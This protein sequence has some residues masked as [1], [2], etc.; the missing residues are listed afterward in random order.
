MRKKLC[1]LMC[2]VLVHC[3]GSAVEGATPIDVNNFSF[4][5]DNDGN[6]ILCHIGMDEVLAWEQSGEAW[7]GV[8]PYCLGDANYDPCAIPENICLSEECYTDNHDGCHCWPATHGVVWSYIQATDRTYLYQELDPND[9]NAIIAPG[10]KYT[11]TYD[12]MSEIYQGVLDSLSIHSGF[13]Y[14]LGD[15]NHVDITSTSYVL[16]VWIGDFEEW[17][18]E[19]VPNLTLEWVCPPGHPD[20][21]EVL[22]IKFWTPS[23]GGSVRAYVQVDNIRLEWSWATEAF[24]PYPAD[25]AED[26]PRD[27][28][29]HWSPG[30]W[31]NRHIVYFSDDLS[32]VSNLLEDA[33]QGIHDVNN[34]SV[35]E[36]DGNELDLAKTYYWRIVEVNE[37]YE[38]QPGLSDPPWVGDVWSFTVTGYATNPSPADGATDVSLYSVLKW[39]PGTDSEEHDIYF[40][41]DFD[42]VNDANDS[43]L[44]VFK[45]T[46]VYGAN[47]YDPGILDLGQKYYWRIDEVRNSGA[48]VVKGRIW[49]F[50][51][52][53]YFVI[54]DMESYGSG[55]S[56]ITN[57]WADYYENDST[58]EI[59]LETDVNYV[60]SGQSMWYIFENSEDPYYAETSR[61]FNP[62][63][64]WTAAGF[65]VLTL[66]FRADMTN[67]ASA[68]QPMYVFISDGV[69]TGIVKYDDSNDL[70]RGWIGWQEWNI[71]L[72]GFVEDEP[73]LDLSSIASMGIV[74]G[75]GNEAGDGYVYIDDIRL[76][77]TRCVVE[78]ATGSFTND[79]DVD[80]YDLFVLARDWLVS[81]IG[82]ITASAPS[83]TGLH[84]RWMMNDNASD[85]VVLD[86][87]TNGNNGVLYDAFDV[88]DAPVEG[89]TINHSVTPGAVD[90]Y[91]LEFDGFDDFVELPAMNVS[92]N[93]ITITAWVKRDI[94]GHIYDGIVMS[95]NNYDPCG[96]IPGPNYTAGL[97]FGSDTSDW[98]ANY[99]LSFMWTGFS[100]EWHTE[101]FVAPEEW[102]FTALTVAPDVATIYLSDGIFL[103]AA[104]N[105]DSYEP[106]P[107]H[108]AFHI[109][110]QM[111]F[112]PPS[113]SDRFFPGAIDEVCIYTRTL[114]PKEIASLAGVSSADIP[115][116]PWRANTDGDNDVDLQDYAMMADNWL[117]EVLWP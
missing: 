64:D 19:W 106:L 75:D 46:H 104:R 70:I 63:Q 84:G 49:R 111:Q 41:T 39:E 25:E 36:Y 1:L 40:G 32:E 73:L 59:Y 60:Q 31:A 71:D 66:D 9:P 5:F 28:E 61:E 86:S 103:Q 82:S 109:A 27:V 98:S 105:Y 116:E 94:S 33:N 3:L 62:A 91:A 21:N 12:A 30:L 45:A 35:L 43:D 15:A 96:V 113:E 65:K 115:L 16:P 81:G 50:T 107:W 85:S 101:L 52:A 51:V 87:S 108:T 72:Q 110:D 47:S 42:E 102:T 8:D 92:T 80:I 89:D 2:F 79:C 95:S 38:P 6:Q 34:W 88:D 17:E 14:G 117:T 20:I 54:D 76:Y 100:W 78:E 99:E 90:S 23:P 77:P 10:R 18:H 53:E 44:N 13:F 48:D 26:V 74:I 11:L 112:G 4:E 93:T 24:E 114:S 29:L 56:T 57:T 58:A 69:Y 67:E 7:V 97:Q 55:S 37:D 22:G 83:I 68:V